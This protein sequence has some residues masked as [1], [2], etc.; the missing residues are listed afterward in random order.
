[1]NFKEVFSQE[2]AQATDVFA[3]Q[4]GVLRSLKR[5]TPKASYVVIPSEIVFSGSLD[6]R[7]I[8]ATPLIRRFLP[9]VFSD[10]D[11][12]SR[13][14][15]IGLRQS[16]DSRKESMVDYRQ[17]IITQGDLDTVFFLPGWSNR[18]EE[19]QAY[20]TAHSAGIMPFV[21]TDWQHQYL[22]L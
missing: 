5:I 16:D 11:V 15:Q 1:M 7:L 19:M 3:V 17:M 18:D 12:F 21:F 4:N 10:L 2:L 22:Q 14:I 6:N 20:F 13:D 9:N 8:V